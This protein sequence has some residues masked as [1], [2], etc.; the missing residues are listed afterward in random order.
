MANDDLMC[1][2][3]AAGGRQEGG[4]GQHHAAR[5]GLLVWPR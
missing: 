3:R 4:A 1:D 2:G 5:L